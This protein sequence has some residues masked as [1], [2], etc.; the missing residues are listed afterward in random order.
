MLFRS[1]ASSAQPEYDEG[2]LEEIDKNV[3]SVGLK[4][5]RAGN[6]S[7][8]AAP[9]EDG[10][11]LLRDAAILFFE[12]GQGSTS[13]LQRRFRVGYARAARIVDE[14]EQMGVVGPPEGSK[15]RAVLMGR[16]QI[17]EIFGEEGDSLIS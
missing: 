16:A 5:S 9:E 7:A 2:V 6:G 17:D 15:P 10:D 11:T 14:L 3:E 8:G 1:K 13:M 12:A 4:G